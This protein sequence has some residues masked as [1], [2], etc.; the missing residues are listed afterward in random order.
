MYLSDTCVLVY[1]AAHIKELYAI[2]ML[3]SNIF[4]DIVLYCIRTLG[5]DKK[6]KEA[7][8]YAGTFIFGTRAG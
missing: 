3:L 7:V 4:Y 2:N 6:K 1:H 5:S 8:D